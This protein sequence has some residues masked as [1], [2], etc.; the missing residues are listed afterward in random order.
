MD[1]QQGGQSAGRAGRGDDLAPDR[2]AMRAGEVEAADGDRIEA[3]ELVGVDRGEPGRSP[4]PPQPP[5]IVG[6]GQRIEPPDPFGM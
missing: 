6:G 1:Q 3:L 2:V 4:R 5:Q